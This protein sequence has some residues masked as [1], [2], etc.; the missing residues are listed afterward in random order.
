MSDLHDPPLISKCG[1]LEVSF[2]YDSAASRVVVTIIQ[3]REIPAKDRGGA[4]STQ[5]HKY[6]FKRQSESE[7][8]SPISKLLN[9]PIFSSKHR[10]KKEQKFINTLQL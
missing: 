1:S 9:A 5:V 8:K 7:A 10:T 3:A 4:N 6:C 2:S